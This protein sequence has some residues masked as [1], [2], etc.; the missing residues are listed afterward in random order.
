MSALLLQRPVIV[1]TPGKHRYFWHPD[2]TRLVY[3]L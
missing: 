3:V 1:F 2:S